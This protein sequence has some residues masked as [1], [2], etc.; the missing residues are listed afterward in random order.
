MRCELNTFTDVMTLTFST[1][2]SLI[3]SLGQQPVTEDSQPAL[4]VEPVAPSTPKKAR[5]FSLEEYLKLRAARA[6]EQPPKPQPDT[7]TSTESQPPESDVLHVKDEVT[8]PSQVAPMSA[9]IKHSRGWWTFVAYAH[10]LTRFDAEAPP[11]P[12]PPRPQAADDMDM[13]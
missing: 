7:Q 4:P 13:D 3:F 12:P 6:S 9:E 10:I 1:Q 5:V 11:P 2:S 8:A